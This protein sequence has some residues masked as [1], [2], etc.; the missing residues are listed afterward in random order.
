MMG[1][2]PLIA[3]NTSSQFSARPPMIAA[4]TA[5]KQLPDEDTLRRN[6]GHRSDDDQIA[7]HSGLDLWHQRPFLA[8]D[9]VGHRARQRGEHPLDAGHE[10]RLVGVDLLLKR[11][12]VQLP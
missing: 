3:P 9:R 12:E 6:I 1:G 4:A 11:A 7:E 2:T 8:V 5:S 10:L